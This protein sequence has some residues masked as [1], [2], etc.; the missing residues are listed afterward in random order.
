[1]LEY[2]ED[3]IKPS[4]AKGQSVCIYT[5]YNVKELKLFI[6][7]VRRMPL[8]ESKASSASS[9]LIWIQSDILVY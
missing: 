9:S 7:Y 3:T 8:M 4:T 1:M 6:C 5:P 2:I